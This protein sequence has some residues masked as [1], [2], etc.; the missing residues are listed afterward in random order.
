VR[1]YVDLDTPD[2]NRFPALAHARGFE[3][4]LEPGQA[5]YM[6]PGWW[7]E[8]HYLEAG[9]GVSLRAA[10]DGL[11]LRARSARNL[12]ITSPLDRLAN[13]LAAGAWYRWKC[14]RAARRAAALGAAGAAAGGSQA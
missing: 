10:P 2:L 8:F 14:R 1:S 6:P 7:H 3:V 13:R 11:R 9:M 4:V 12:L 5:L